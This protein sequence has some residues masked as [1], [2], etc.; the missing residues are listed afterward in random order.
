MKFS[1]TMFQS[2]NNTGIEVPEG[3]VEA[4]GAGKRPPVNVT[5][6]GYA[7]RSTI[8]PMGGQYLIPFSSDKRKATG[9]GGGDAIE[10]ELT[11]DT[12]PRTVEPPEDLAA[13]LAAAP[14]AAE[15]FAA[16]SHS[17][18]KAHVT[19]IE[20]AKAQDTR[21]RRIAKTVAELTP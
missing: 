5:V 17:R 7:Y 13:A 4:L 8:A 3:V 21:E 18:Q 6:N 12:A 2:G 10:V 15:A 20:G 9:I 19:S 14:G 16:L 11:L 1:T